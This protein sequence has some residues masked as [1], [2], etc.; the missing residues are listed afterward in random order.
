M[1]L[2]FFQ[3][4]SPDPRG[5]DVGRVNGGPFST[6]AGP[7]TGTSTSGTRHCP[8]R[9]ATYCHPSKPRRALKPKSSASN[10]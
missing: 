8:S 9:S 6:C 2:A 5:F 7:K 4:V 1:L 10:P 3:W